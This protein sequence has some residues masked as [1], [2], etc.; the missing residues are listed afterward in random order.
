MKKLDNNT[1]RPRRGVVLSGA[2]GMDNAGDD[3]ILAAIIAELRRLDRDIP[4]TVIARRP[5]RTAR[6]FGVAAVGR[7]N[8]PGWLRAMG[9]AKLFLS[10]GGSLLQNATSRRSL[11]FYLAAI[12]LAK[13]RGC[14]V[15]LYGCGI[16]PVRGERVRRAVADCLNRCAD[17]AALR[18]RDSLELLR[19]LGV[20]RPRLLLSADP[21]L[22]MDPVPG[23]RERRAGFILRS[24]PGFW[25]RVPAFARAARY[26][27][28]RYR[29]P[30]VFIC[31]A[32]GDRDAVR[33]VCAEL[34]DVPYAVTSDARRTGRMGLVLSMRLHGLIFA[35]RDGAPAAG[36]S[37]DPK[38]DTFCRE[39]GLPVLSLADVTE[40]GLRRLI[41]DA[42]HLDGEALSAAAR[43]LRERERVNLQTAAELLAQEL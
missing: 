31:L 26:V 19:S 22:G 32:P 18:D 25:N 24:W 28:E 8:I 41:D 7:L 15:A 14:G 27:W 9:R 2:Y 4:V 17:A 37:Y 13:A 30:P 21:V 33:S 5:K 29:L 36:V 11:W 38:V 1:R 40:E 35:L 23:D 6:R 16:G 43:T 10:G 3:A 42:A 20:D 12:R 34:G 39:A